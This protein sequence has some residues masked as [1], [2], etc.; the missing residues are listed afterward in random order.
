MPSHWNQVVDPEAPD[1]E[2]S[3][4]FNCE[5]VA[6]RWRCMS[7]WATAVG[8]PGNLPSTWT[9]VPRPPWTVHL[10]PRFSCPDHAPDNLR[11]A[12]NQWARYD[13]KSYEIPAADFEVVRRSLK[14]LAAQLDGL[15]ISGERADGREV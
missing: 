9:E 3:R 11:V 12:R 13:Q 10:G 14:A 5:V 6:V 2:S 7:C 8:A 15:R 4:Y 1:A